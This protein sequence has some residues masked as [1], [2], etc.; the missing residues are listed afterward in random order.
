MSIHTILTEVNLE[1]GSNHKKA[2]FTANKGDKLLQRVLKM[3]YDKVAYTYGLSLD[4]A[5]KHKKSADTG[6][7]GAT[8]EQALN[9]MEDFLATRE[10][11]GHQAIEVF[12]EYRK[13]LSSDDKK[14]I[15]QI[16]DRDLK[17][18]FGKTLINKIW[19][20][21]I[22]KPVYC[23][24]DVY[25]SKTAKNIKFPAIVQLKA[26][27]TYREFHVQNGSVQAQS[28]SGEKYDY[29]IIEE[30]MKNY[31][32]GYYTGELT[33]QGYSDRSEGNGLI[34]SDNPPHEDIILELWDYITDE[35]YQRAGL[36]DKKNPCEVPYVTRFNY[37]IGIVKE[38][39]NIRIIPTEFID[40]LQEAL[41]FTSE[42]MNQGFEGAILKDKNMV[43]K[44][45]TSKEQLKLKLEIDVEMRITGFQ[46]G[47]KGT[48]RELTFGAMI[49]ENDEGTIKGRCSGFTDVQLEDF[50]SRRDE[51]IGRV[52]TVQFNDL[53]K[54]R[55]NDYYALSHPRFI[56][57]RD[58]KNETDTL[59]KA[60]KLR[61][62]AMELA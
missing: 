53:S 17:I 47:K 10:H 46:E 51:L 22:T 1:N 6:L 26:D 19:K 45:G 56:E 60:F 21:L 59:E 11:T 15:E 31:P 25:S 3:T 41:E 28:R 32:D 29:P 30:Q 54:A 37:L 36:K 62:M 61:E 9:Y 18:N 12:N 2:V 40:T 24:C 14:L 7:V 23:R 43:F 8:L 42:W 48:K 34:N 55:D 16:L 20:D 35:E 58:D 52:I 5:D 27:G 4:G 39:K 44:D 57:L 50:N 33:V 13:V 49:F 38:S